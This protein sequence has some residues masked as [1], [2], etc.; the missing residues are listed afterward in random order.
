MSASLTPE[1][2]RRQI[3]QQRL[4]EIN[5]LHSYRV[6]LRSDGSLLCLDDDGQEPDEET[7]RR[8]AAAL[9]RR[10][11]PHWYVYIGRRKSGDAYKIGISQNPQG[12]ARK[13]GIRLTH[14]IECGS[15][16]HARDIEKHLH[17]LFTDAQ[18]E[19]KREWFTL[20]REDIEQIKAFDISAEVFDLYFDTYMALYGFDDAEM[21]AQRRQENARE[22]RRLLREKQ[23]QNAP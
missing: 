10:Y 5:M 12:R 9:A 6:A 3:A 8:L 7:G 20:E 21:D 2:F 11:A 13:L 4:V 15:R 1:E 23:R 18:R 22:F 19:L 17:A 16:K 14:V